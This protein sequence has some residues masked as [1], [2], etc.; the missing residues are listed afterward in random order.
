MKCSLC[1]ESIFCDVKDFCDTKLFLQETAAF[2]AMEKNV[3]LKRI[4]AVE[5]ILFCLFNLILYVWVNYFSVM[6][7]RSSWVEPVLSKDKC[8]LL[9]D[10]TQ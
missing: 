6:S 3:Q 10:T 8:G 2:S 9:K 7:D 1:M 4:I 5:I